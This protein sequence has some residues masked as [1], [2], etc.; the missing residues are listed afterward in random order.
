MKKAFILNL[1]LL[2][3]LCA[4]AT[5]HSFNVTAKARIEVQKLDHMLQL[6][7][8][9]ERQVSIIFETYY[10]AMN[11]LP[12]D[13]VSRKEYV[14]QIGLLKAATRQKVKQTLSQDQL[15]IY[16]KNIEIQ[17]SSVAAKHAIIRAKNNNQTILK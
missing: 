8:K 5:K 13:T 3:S 10:M 4:F 16:N 2:L 9:Q 12:S 11:V 15:L 1:L 14:K 17:K 7:P 6:S